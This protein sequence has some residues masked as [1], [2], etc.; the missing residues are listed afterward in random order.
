[1]T[2]GFSSVRVFGL[3]A[4]PLLGSPGGKVAPKVKVEKVAVRHGD[5]GARI[6]FSG[7]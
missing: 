3:N 6:R 1:V 5:L 7:Q 2:G 4:S